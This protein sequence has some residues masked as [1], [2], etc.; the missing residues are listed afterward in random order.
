MTLCA[1]RMVRPTLPNVLTILRILLVP[2]IVYALLQETREGDIV[3]AV[4]FAVASAT[5]YVDGWLARTR[6]TVSDFGKLMDPIADKLLVTTVLIVLVAL[7]RLEA[8]VAAVIIVRELAVTMSRMAETGQGTV[9]AANRWGKV[10]T[11]TQVLTIFLL[12]A[13]DDSPGWLDALVYLTVFVTVVSGLEY[14]L[15]LRRRMGER[16]R[17]GSAA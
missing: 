5:D 7:D 4:V 11:L 13:I 10:K 3:A 6:G 8:W 9:V 15:G 16:T 2:V 14:F 1:A 12:I 17:A